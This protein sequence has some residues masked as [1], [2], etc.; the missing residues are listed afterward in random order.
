MQGKILSVLVRWSPPAATEF[1]RHRLEGSPLARRLARGAIWSLVGAVSTRVLTL[2]SS[3]IVVRLLGKVTLGEFGMVQS[4]LAMLGTFAGLGL[5][6]TATKYT[7]EFR[8]RDSAR[9]G[10]VLG[11]II[12]AGFVSGVVMSV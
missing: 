9:V 3:I 12:A 5:G 4:T 8:E 11:M 6:L 1:L 10:R 7:A 2:V